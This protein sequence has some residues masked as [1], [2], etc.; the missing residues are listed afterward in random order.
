LNFKPDRAS[1]R[2]WASQNHLAS[3]TRYKAVRKPGKRWQAR[4]LGARWQCDASPH[5]WLP[6]NPEKQARLDLLAA[7]THLNVGARR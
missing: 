2:R 4:D 1:V 7:A 3:D 5:A 6:G